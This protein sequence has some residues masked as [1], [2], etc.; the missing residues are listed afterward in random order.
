MKI[1]C[2]NVLLRAS[3]LLPGRQCSCLNHQL[4]LDGDED[5]D[6]DENGN[7]DQC[8]DDGNGHDDSD[9]DED[10]TGWLLSTALSPHET[11]LS[12]GLTGFTGSL[13]V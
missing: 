9:E 4:P 5:D 10:A 12:I 13:S 11:L 1:I 8:G 6:E 7:D 2:E 3:G